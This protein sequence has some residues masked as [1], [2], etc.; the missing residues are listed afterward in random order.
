MKRNGLTTCEERETLVKEARFSVN[1]VN[2]APDGL[3]AV[4]ANMS[5]K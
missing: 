1:V 2:P 5:I 3:S 4:M